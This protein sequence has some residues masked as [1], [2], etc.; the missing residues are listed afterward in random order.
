MSAAAHLFVSTGNGATCGLSAGVAGE[1][2]RF[3]GG[4]P[5]RERGVEKLRGKSVLMG[6]NRVWN[7]KEESILLL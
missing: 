6:C 4:G 2:G 5:G 1:E 7:P 3:S